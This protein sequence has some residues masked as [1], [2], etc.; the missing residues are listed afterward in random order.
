MNKIYVVRGSCYKGS[1]S[2]EDYREF[3]WAVKGFS[4]PE[5]AQVY[6]IKCQDFADSILKKFVDDKNAQYKGEY[7]DMMR[8]YD[9]ASRMDD[10]INGRIGPRVQEVTDQDVFSSGIKNKFDKKMVIGEKPDD[11][12]Q[13]GEFMYGAFYSVET[14]EMEG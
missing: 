1:F 7:A 8:N 6:R 14:V 4:T 3:H 2:W 9:A 5:A 12:F 11:T 13:A 10:E